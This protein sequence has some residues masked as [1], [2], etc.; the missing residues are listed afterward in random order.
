MAMKDTCAITIRYRN[1][2]LTYN[3]R[4]RSKSVVY[5]Y[6]NIPVK[7]LIRVGQPRG[8]E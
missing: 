7:M 1:D 2:G 6:R 3:V 8:R 5:H 4:N